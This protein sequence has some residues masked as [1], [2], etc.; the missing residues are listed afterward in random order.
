MSEQ[1]PPSRWPRAV[2]A[3][4]VAVVAT[5]LGLIHALQSSSAGSQPDWQRAIPWGL[6][7]SYLLVPV[8]ACAWYLAQKFPLT[9]PH[10]VRNA[11]LHITVAIALGA[12]HPYALVW[13]N[14]L[15]VSPRWFTAVAESMLPYLHFWYWQDVILVSLVYA[16]S[17]F[18][19]LS[20]R[21]YRGYQEG[22]LRAARLEAQ[23]AHSNLAALKMQLHPHFLFNALHSISALQVTDSAAAQRMTTL[24]GDFLRMTLREFDQQQVPLRREIEFLECYLAIEKMRFGERL[25][26]RFEIAAELM[27]ALVP[28]LLLQPMVENAVRHAIAPFNAGGG[29][30]VRAARHEHQLRLEVEDN[31]PGIPEGTSPAVPKREGLG[32]ANSRARLTQLYGS[33]FSFRCEN[34][35]PSGLKVEFLIPFQTE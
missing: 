2:V 34:V 22:L 13:V 31:G 7:F 30:V 32:F 6:T 15:F 9:L 35:R 28:Q 11:A 18:A 26:F 17:L 1:A 25:Q 8:G 14:S 29:V 24:L 16:I 5:L 23:L 33:A 4:L 10:G 3:L 20:M 21:Y 27:Q 12:L 19:A